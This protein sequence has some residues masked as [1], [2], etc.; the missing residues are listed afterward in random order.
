MDGFGQGWSAA[1]GPRG[2]R[3]SDG[4]RVGELQRTVEG[5]LLP[6]E[7]LFLLAPRPPPPFSFLGA[8][9]PPPWSPPIP[10]VVLFPF[11]M[12]C[13]SPHSEAIQAPEIANTQPD[14]IAG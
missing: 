4:G 9:A 6:F 11:A 14:S 13:L 5:G 7:A 2:G 1:A 12:R 10:C 8:F 3:G